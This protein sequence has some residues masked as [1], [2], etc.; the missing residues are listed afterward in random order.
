MSIFDNL[1]GKPCNPWLKQGNNLKDGCQIETLTDAITCYS[2]AIEV[3]PKCVEAWHN[4]G[5]CY[6]LLRKEEEAIQC[7]D[8]AIKINP[9]YAE[10]WYNKGISLK[11]S[12]RETESQNCLN[13]SIEIDPAYKKFIENEYDLVQISPGTVRVQNRPRDPRKWTKK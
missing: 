6:H 3:D 8:E 4:K 10:V 1:F 2:K 12:G 7:Y 13:K 9:N 11:R 5:H